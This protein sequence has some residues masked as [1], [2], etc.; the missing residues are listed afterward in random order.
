MNE[1]GKH[2]PEHDVESWKPYPH[3]LRSIF[4]SRSS[5]IRPMPERVGV[6]RAVDAQKQHEVL[7]RRRRS[8]ASS[9]G[10]HCATG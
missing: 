10:A 5:G 3:D 7:I 9:R 8:A 6:A 4:G 1:A 2:E